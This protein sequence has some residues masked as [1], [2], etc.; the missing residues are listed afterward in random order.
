MNESVILYIGPR[1]LL[2]SGTK[3]FAKGLNQKVT[4]PPKSVSLFLLQT[5]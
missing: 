1:R 5:G 4:K 2:N 3:S